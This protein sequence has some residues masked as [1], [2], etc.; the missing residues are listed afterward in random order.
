MIFNNIN[1][2][3]I[4]NISNNTQG[5]FLQTPFWAKFKCLHG[6]SKLY[7]NVSF[8]AKND[9]ESKSVKKLDYNCSILIRK[10][11]KIFNVAYIPMAIDITEIDYSFE[12]Y[13]KL[14]KIFCKK[15]KKLLP[16]NTIMI[17]MDP[18]I[19]FSVLQIREFSKNFV[20][21][22]KPLK[23]AKTDIQPPDT[24]LL[25]ITN[26]SDSLLKAM[27]NKWRYN[28]NLAQKKGV[29][30]KKCSIEDIDIF[31]ELYQQTAKRDGIALHSKEYYKSLLRLNNELS[32]DQ[33]IQINLYIASH[34]ND[35]LAAIITLFTNKEAV[36]LYGASSN[37]KR[38]YMSAYLLQW[39]AIQDAQNYGCEVYDFYGI[40]PTDDEKHPMHGLYRFKTGFGGKI[41]H[42]IGSIDFPCSV[43]YYLYIFLE[44]LRN[45]YHK[46]IKKI[47]VGRL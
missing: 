11:A 19:D 16:I 9:L 40:P 41:V 10:I 3:L 8:E 23:K 7:V 35:N 38:N 45:F 1:V 32:S 30:V 25:D 17:R 44:N 14:L 39:T 33:K 31:Y 47:L 34:E 43:V 22:V 36:Y 12:E 15:L 24:V 6:W 4:E 26:D 13:L 5:R 20:K 18:P 46:K 37:I 27:K 2:E 28:I 29:I 21:K 42:R